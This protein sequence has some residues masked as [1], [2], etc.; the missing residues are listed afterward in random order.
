M[1]ASLSLQLDNAEADRTKD[2][3]EEEDTGPHTDVNNKTGA[4]RFDRRH[5][6]DNEKGETSDDEQCRDD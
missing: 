3:G 6:S 1:Q 4:T 2:H 5:S